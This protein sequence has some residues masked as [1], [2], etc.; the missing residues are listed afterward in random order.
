MVEGRAAR[1]ASCRAERDKKRHEVIGVRVSTFSARAPF[2]ILHKA[3]A[4]APGHR[5]G[6]P[7]AEFVGP[8]IG[9]CTFAQRCRRIAKRVDGATAAE[10]QNAVVPQ[11]C[12]AAPSATCCAGS[13]WRWMESCTTGTSPSGNMSISGTQAP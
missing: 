12:K 11:R 8:P 2:P 3:D 13:K 7:A 10:D 4:V 6:Q 5:V 9:G 1:V